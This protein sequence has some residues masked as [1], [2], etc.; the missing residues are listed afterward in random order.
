M[1]FA[2]LKRILK[3]DRLR[4][5]GLNGAR[6]EFLLAATAKNLHKMAKLML[7]AAQ[8]SKRLFKQ[9]LGESL[10]VGSPCE[11][12]VLSIALHKADLPLPP[13]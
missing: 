13:P 3:L 2:H 4:L 5:R 10:R 6:D 8:Y 11:C 9:N 12:P 1:L 7:L